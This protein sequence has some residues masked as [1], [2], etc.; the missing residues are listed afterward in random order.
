M[1]RNDLD[2]EWDQILSGPDLLVLKVG[3][4]S[5]FNAYVLPHGSPWTQRA[6]IAPIDKLQQSIAVARLR[7]D[8]VCVIGDL[9]GRTG[10][11]HVHLHTHPPRF[12]MD[13]KVNT[14][15]R[16]I[17]R[18]VADHNLRI[19]N[20]DSR[21][22]DCSWPWTFSQRQTSKNGNVRWCRSVIDYALCDPAACAMVI[23]FEVLPMGPW[24]DHAPLAL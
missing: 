7:G 17:L 5:L 4:L 21:F 14:Q 20:G 2:A 15:G 19:L 8:A 22:G 18:L 13:D 11:R 16:A 9:N 23:N 3:S 12:S 1:V 6:Q 10:C 24:S